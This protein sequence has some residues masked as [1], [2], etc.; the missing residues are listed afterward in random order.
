MDRPISNNYNSNCPLLVKLVSGNYC[1]N[2][3]RQT[4][5][6]II[7]IVLLG[8]PLSYIVYLQGNYYFGNYFYS[9]PAQKGNYKNSY[10]RDKVLIYSKPGQEG[11]YKNSYPRSFNF[12]IGLTID[13]YLYIYSL[14]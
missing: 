3:P 12:L 7:V 8:G 14:V 13:I 2:Y 5:V 1:S 6:I 10:P 11:N 9:Y 4:R